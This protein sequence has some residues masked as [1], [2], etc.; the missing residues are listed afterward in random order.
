VLFF[1]SCQN[2]ANHLT[3][4]GYC[5]L[6]FLGLIFARASLQSGRAATT[7]AF[8]T[9]R[10]HRNAPAPTCRPAG[11]TRPARSA[12][13]PPATTASP[14][15]SART[16]SPTSACAAARPPRNRTS[17]RMPPELL[18]SFAFCTCFPVSEISQA[19]SRRGCRRKP[20]K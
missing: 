5:C 13:R 11:A 4:S 14:S 17:E 6:V 7:A 8:A 9:R 3:S 16:S 1:P 10:C 20:N 19:S 2:H 15:T 12:R 18:I